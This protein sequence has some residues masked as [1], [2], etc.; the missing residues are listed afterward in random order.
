M[1]PQPL[2]AQSLKD[3][4]TLIKDIPHKHALWWTKWMR[5]EELPSIILNEGRLVILLKFIKF[6]SKKW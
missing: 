2:P 1:P 5:E 6:I 3:M 4:D